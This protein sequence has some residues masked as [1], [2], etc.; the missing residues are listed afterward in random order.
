MS[1][2]PV[3]LDVTETPAE[4]TKGFG[5]IYFTKLTRLQPLQERQENPWEADPQSGPGLR[6][7]FRMKILSNMYHILIRR[8]VRNSTQK[9]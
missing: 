2:T 4:E 1:G 7:Q 9:H 3:L 5:H 6:Q 8:R